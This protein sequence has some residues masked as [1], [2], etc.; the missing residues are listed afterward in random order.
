MIDTICY[1]TYSNELQAFF[2]GTNFSLQ[3]RSTRSMNDTK[4]LVK[5]STEKENNGGDWMQYMLASEYEKA[6]KIT[7]RDMELRKGKPCFHLPRHLQFVWD[8]RSLKDK[9]VLVRCYHGLG[10]TIQFIRYA[11][12]LKAVAKEVIVWAQAPL[13]PLLQSVSGIDQMLPLHDGTPQVEYDVDVEVM[14]LPY[15]FR[16]TLQTIPSNI[17]Y[18]FAK[19]GLLAKTNNRMRVGLVWKAGDYDQRRGV[20][21]HLL[22]SLAD[23][24]NADFYILQSDARTA[25]WNHEFGTWPGDVSL[26]AYA[27]I[28]RSMDLLIS[29]DSM[30]A[31]L[32]GALGIPVWTLL[33]AE[34]DWRWMNTRTDSP[35]YST[36]RLLR[37]PTMGDW[38]TVIAKVKSDLQTLTA[39]NIVYERRSVQPIPMRFTNAPIFPRW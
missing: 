25:G 3:Q 39:G 6:W 37:Q 31:H 8:G 5:Q 18:L 14:E 20:P 11:P 26:Q 27:G 7:D 24:H 29:V 15:I 16:T 35:W 9:R 21:F 32:A 17:P 33:H 2:A 13:L 19:P 23:V 36:M 10:D 38:K 12:L 34:A 28:M 4:E 30:P 1:R 22:K